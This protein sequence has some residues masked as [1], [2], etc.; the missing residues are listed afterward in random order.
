MVSEHTT[1]KRH[2]VTDGATRSLVCLTVCLLVTAVS[3]AKTTEP[4]NRKSKYRLGGRL[5]GSC[6][7]FRWRPDPPPA[8][9]DPLPTE[10]YREM[11][12]GMRSKVCPVTAACAAAAMRFVATNTVPTCLNVYT[13]V[14]VE[15]RTSLQGMKHNLAGAE[16]GLL[17]G[18]I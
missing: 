10:K 15:P 11:R 4:I 1:L 14:I 8:R 7:R 3:P 18:N 6:I 5:V 13:Q 17:A 9:R 12:C 16:L 2:T